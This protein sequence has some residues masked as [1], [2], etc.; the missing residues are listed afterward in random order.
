MSG[1]RRAFG[2]SKALAR[3]YSAPLSRTA[4]RSCSIGTN[5]SIAMLYIEIFIGHPPRRCQRDV[6]EPRAD[7]VHQHPA[8]AIELVSLSLNRRAG[9]DQ[10]KIV[11]RII[12][13]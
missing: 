6:R 1:A 9:R 13:A 12:Q 11:P 10:G 2:R 5:V 4:D 8:L 3:E 7:V